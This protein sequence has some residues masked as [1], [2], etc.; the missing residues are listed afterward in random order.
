MELQKWVSSYAGCD[1]GSPDE[2][3]I[4]FVG[5]EWGYGK[6]AGQTAAERDKAVRDY[7]RGSMLDG[8]RSGWSDLVDDK[9]CLSDHTDYTFGRNSAKLISAIK[10]GEVGS[11]RSVVESLPDTDVFEPV[12]KTV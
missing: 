4:W 5:I 2:S 3:S 8:I 7:H 10:G 9:Y 12:D 11:Y 1:G 6:D